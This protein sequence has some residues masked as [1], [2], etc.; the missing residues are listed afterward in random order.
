MG[1]IHIAYLGFFLHGN[2]PKASSTQNYLSFAI[3]PRAKA[4]GFLGTNFYKGCLR[5]LKTGFETL[6]KNL[7]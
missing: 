1:Y 5:D 3:H 2:V 4:L 7:P 6:P